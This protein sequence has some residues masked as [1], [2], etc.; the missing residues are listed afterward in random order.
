MRC[1]NC[2]CHMTAIPGGWHCH[3]C[4]KVVVNEKEPVQDQANERIDSS[5]KGRR[6]WI[7]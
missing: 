1:P 6:S 7:I 2:N 3:G 5:R 4:G